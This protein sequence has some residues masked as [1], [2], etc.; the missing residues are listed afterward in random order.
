MNEVNYVGICNQSKGIKTK[1][2]LRIN[3]G[4]IHIQTT[5]SVAVVDNDPSYCTGIKCDQTVYSRRQHHY[6]A[7]E[8][9]ER[10]YRQTVTDLFQVAMSKSQPPVTEERIRNTNSIL[11]SYSATCMK[12]TVTYISANSTVTM[13]STGSGKGE[14]FGRRWNCFRCSKCQKARC[15]RHYNRS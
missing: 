12:A 2:D 7:L 5:G 13:K 11:D 8:Q 1:N 14:N 3:D 6:Q 15:W 10:E 4:T 9:Q